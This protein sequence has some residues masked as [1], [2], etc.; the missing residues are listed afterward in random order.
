MRPEAKRLRL[1]RVSLVTVLGLSGLVIAPGAALERDRSALPSRRPRG[2][3]RSLR[4]LRMRQLLSRRRPPRAVRRPRF[5]RRHGRSS[6]R[7]RRRRP[8]SDPPRARGRSPRHVLRRRPER[9]V[10]SG[11]PSVRSRTR[12]SCPQ[13]PWRSVRSPP[14]RATPIACCSSAGSPCSSSCWATRRSSRSRRACSESSASATR[15]TNWR[16]AACRN[17]QRRAC[18]GRATRTSGTSLGA[19]CSVGRGTSRCAV[20]AVAPARATRCRRG[21]RD[22]DDVVVAGPFHRRPDEQ[23]RL[24]HLLP[25][26]REEQR[27][28][29]HE[30]ERASTHIGGLVDGAQTVAVRPSRTEPG[31]EVARRRARAAEDDALRLAVQPGRAQELHGLRVGR[32]PPDQL[33]GALAGLGHE[34]RHRRRGRVVLE[35]DA[36]GALVTGAVTAG[37]ADDGGQVVGSR[38]RRAGAAVDSGHRVHAAEVDGQRVVVPAVRVRSPAGRPATCGAVAS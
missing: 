29:G 36:R 12:C 26:A 37:A 24:R 7:P 1:A 20:A 15:R 35:R 16:R 8:S 13:P 19:A 4:L 5:R 31:V 28:A 25:R 14:A 21:G 23:R 18:P 38:V 3:A 34:Q 27:P 22:E 17:G 6:P 9:R 11:P 2:S 33:G 10:R 32:R 30:V